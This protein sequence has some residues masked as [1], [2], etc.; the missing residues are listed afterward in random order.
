MGSAASVS[1]G[2]PSPAH[3]G[4]AAVVAHVEELR[5]VLQRI[6]HLSLTP[7][8]ARDF[9]R[10]HSTADVKQ[11]LAMD[12]AESVEVVGRS[13]VGGEAT[14]V[15]KEEVSTL[16]LKLGAAVLTGALEAACARPDEAAK[17]PAGHGHDAPQFP[18]GPLRD[19][20]PIGSEPLVKEV[21]DS[22]V[23]SK[24][25]QRAF[26][27]D[28]TDAASAA[29]L[30]AAALR[31]ANTMRRTVE[32]RCNEEEGIADLAHRVVEA[33]NADFL[34]VYESV[35][36]R[37][38]RN[39]Q[40]NCDAFQK[41]A[42]A[43]T[44]PA[45]GQAQEA[46]DP[47]ELLVHAAAVKPAYD[48]IIDRIVR[49]V[50]GAEASIPDTLKNITRIVEKAV[51]NAEN[52][53]NCTRVFDIV[54]GMVVC[55]DMACVTSVLDKLAKEKDISLVRMKERFFQ[56][57][58][59]GGW[60]DCMVCFVVP[61]GGRPLHVCELQIAHRDLLT[62]RKGLPGHAV[63]NRARNAA[64]LLEVMHECKTYFDPPW[65]CKYTS[66]VVF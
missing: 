28:P 60:R 16:A 38:F 49:S 36:E 14:T 4:A 33:A 44:F 48:Q 10:R 2:S 12:E 13:N 52:P 59:P 65:T 15:P 22:P 20:L 6:A 50:D 26:G 56:N 9:I 11:L 61:G 43:I 51:L 46:T 53:G 62:A 31:L 57:P 29:E 32:R 41:V 47:V 64:E 55:Q 23:L 35:W 3:P 66:T 37:I 5:A 42:A 25:A 27:I 34:P 39:E 8:D 58:S 30:R 45:Q 17:H 19:F 40:A 7:G 24:E 63:Y 1:E 54:R 18:E 21:V